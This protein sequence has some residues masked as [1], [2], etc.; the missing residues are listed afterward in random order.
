MIRG[1]RVGDRIVWSEGA[2]VSA[3]AAELF[4]TRHEYV[5]DM[6]ANQRTA[7]ALSMSAYLGVY[8]NELE[9]EQEPYGWT[10]IMPAE[11]SADKLVQK[12]QDMDAFGRFLV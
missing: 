12:E 9:T 3:Q 1:V 8:T 4:E 2:T 6:P 10:I 11:I 5:G 7:N